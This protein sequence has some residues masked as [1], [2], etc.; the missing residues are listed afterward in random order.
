MIKTPDPS[1]AIPISVWI[2]T[3]VLTL[4]VFGGGFAVFMWYNV[5]FMNAYIEDLL[6]DHTESNMSSRQNKPDVIIMGSSLTKRALC[7]YGTFEMAIDEAKEDIKYEVIY[8][9]RVVLGDFNH[10]IDPI[11]NACPSYLL[12]ES[13]ILCINMFKN[14]VEVKLDFSLLLNEY[15]K[16]LR[17]IPVRLVSHSPNLQKTM[18]G[19]PRFEEEVE[20]D[21]GMEYWDKYYKHARKYRIRSINDFPEWT[22][23][24]EKAHELGILVYILELPRSKEAKDI[25]PLKLQRE[26]EELIEQFKQAYDIGYITFPYDLGQKKYFRDAAHVNKKGAELYSSWLVSVLKELNPVNEN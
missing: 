1:K 8:R 6:L 23:F 21:M 15:R 16:T 25:L 9:K 3:M 4:L 12:I 20:E 24:F 17:S 22:A 13:N 7:N 18:L 26:H 11:S 2:K 5:G 19:D 14:A 10:Y